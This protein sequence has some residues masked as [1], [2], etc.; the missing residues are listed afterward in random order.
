[1]FCAKELLLCNSALFVFY[2]IHMKNVLIIVGAVAFAVLVG[3]FCYTMWFAQPKS[4]PPLDFS[5]T[6]SIQDKKGAII[7]RVQTTS[8]RPLTQEEVSKIVQEFSNG[9]GAK[10]NLTKEQELQIMNALNRK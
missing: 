4:P 3:L 1:M 2:T 8:S 5:A 7:D 9:N 10:Y 6:D